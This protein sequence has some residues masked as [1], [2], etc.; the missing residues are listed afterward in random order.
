M[1]SSRHSPF[2][3]FFNDTATTEIYTLS[4]HDALPIYATFTER[5][6]A[7][8]EEIVMYEG[9]H[10]IAA[11][12]VETVT[13]TNGILIPPDGYLQGLRAICDRHG[14]LLVCDEVMCGLGRTGRWFAADHWKVVPDMI[15]MAKGLT[16]AYLP[17]GA[18]AVSDRHAAHF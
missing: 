4:L 15:T 1:C 18:V 7:E 11:M 9:G 14:I 13:G 5:C 10:T 2:Y 3:F 17:L 16:S 12:F 8:V 6:L